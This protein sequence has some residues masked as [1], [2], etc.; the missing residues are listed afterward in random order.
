MSKIKINDHIK[1]SKLDHE[2][3]GTIALLEVTEYDEDGSILDAYDEDTGISKY[4]ISAAT[5]RKMAK[6]FEVMADELEKGD[7]HELSQA[8]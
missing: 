6:A 7:K 4:R 3:L 8:W 5:L 2:K 1:L